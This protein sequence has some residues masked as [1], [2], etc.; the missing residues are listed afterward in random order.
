MPDLE[1]LRAF[2][3]SLTETIDT[4]GES[5]PALATQAEALGTLHGDAEE[6]LGG[7]HS[8]L[9]PALTALD[10]LADQAD[11]ALAGLD[12][13]AKTGDDGVLT[14]ATDAFDGFEKSLGSTLD[15]AAARIGTESEELGSAGFAALV[16]AFSDAASELEEMDGASEAAFDTLA[17]QLERQEDLFVQALAAATE[18]AEEA[19]EQGRELESTFDASATQAI[20]SIGTSSTGARAV[21]GATNNG[22]GAFYDQVDNRIQSEAQEAAADVK[23]AFEKSAAAV[24][25][26]AEEPLGEP[27]DELVS[28]TLDPLVDELGNWVAQE[29]ATAQ[30]LATWDPLV[31][32]LAASIEVIKVI[33]K[34][35]EVLG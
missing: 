23:A 4:V 26:A 22:A 5:Q 25:E 28:D 1:N 34:A 31:K 13:T 12:N 17:V 32:D 21:H 6:E 33:K 2:I 35:N 9:D 10:T 16:S 19:A 15:Q 27:V 20:E 29:Q 24:R 18:A 7:L 30:A 14:G 3:R 8:E 11:N